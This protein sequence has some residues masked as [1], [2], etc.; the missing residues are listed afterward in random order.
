MNQIQLRVQKRET[1]K[2]V[3]K[4]YRRNGRI[5]GVFYVREVNE[6]D[7]KKQTNLVSIPILSAPLDLRDVVYT[8]EM[9]I[10][11]LFIEGEEEAR[12]CVLK[13]VRFDPVTDEIKHFDLVGIRRGFTMSFEV[14]ITLKGT[15]IGVRD[16]GI[17]QQSLLKVQIDCLPKNLPNSIEVD[18]ND[19]RIG[20]AIYI[21]DIEQENFKIN[22][23]PDAVVVSVIAPRVVK[24]AAEGAPKAED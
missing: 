20:H 5:P 6:T 13:E 4:R 23:Q 2:Q 3:S 1:G 17:L 7:G 16:G 9:H 12:E 11:D 14:P 18:I 24:S 22:G 21:K 15:S 19:L 8:S 10:I